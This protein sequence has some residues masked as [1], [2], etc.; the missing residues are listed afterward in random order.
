MWC[1]K[2]WNLNHVRTYYLHYISCVMSNFSLCY[3]YIERKYFGEER[4][5]TINIYGENTIR[6]IAKAIRLS[7]IIIIHELN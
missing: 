7:V 6:N 5:Y 3:L 2:S 4:K 1:K